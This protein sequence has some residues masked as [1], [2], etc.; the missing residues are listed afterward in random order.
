MN[1]YEDMKIK[2]EVKRDELEE[3]LGRI[4]I[5]KRKEHDKDFSEQASEREN[6]EVVD[7]LGENIMK[8]LEQ[9]ENSLKR[10]ENNEYNICASCKGIIKDERLFAL[11]YTSLC[12]ECAGKI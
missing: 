6:D 2:L 4:R 7:I 1:S 3:R 8:E 10:M 5:S 9:I 11:P 12:I